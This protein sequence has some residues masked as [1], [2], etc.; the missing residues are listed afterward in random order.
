MFMAARAGGCE[1]PLL[2]FCAV[3]TRAC[4]SW[5]P[6]VYRPSRLSAVWSLWPGPMVQLE[7]RGTL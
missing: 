1:G 7:C 3:L 4:A 2:Y 6:T 5:M